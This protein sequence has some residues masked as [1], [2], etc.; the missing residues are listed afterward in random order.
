MASLLSWPFRSP[1]VG[2]AFSDRFLLALRA[3]EPGRVL[4]RDLPVGLLAPAVATLNIQSVRDLAQLASELIDELRTRRA[5]VS[6]MLPDRTL[7]TAFF[8]S[9]TL[10]GNGGTRK[11]LAERLG[12]PASE[13]RSDFCR[14]AR[15]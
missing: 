14:G 8:P 6:L 12:F 7:V 13:A 5:L 9:G 4:R 10:D 2:L 11:A 1:R 15:P 3:D